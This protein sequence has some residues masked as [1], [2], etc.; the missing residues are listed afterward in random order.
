M[1]VNAA[2][3]DKTAVVATHD[4]CIGAADQ[5]MTQTPSAQPLAYYLLDRDGLVNMANLFLGSG[6]VEDP[7]LRRAFEEG[8]AFVRGSNPPDTGELPVAPRVTCVTLTKADRF[9]YL[10]R[11]LESYGNQTYPNR[12]LVIVG[13][14]VGKI[15]EY[16]NTLGRSDVQVVHAPEGLDLASRRNVGLDAASGEVICQW[17]DDDV[18]H[19]ERISGQLRAMAEAKARASILGEALQY[20]EQ[21][22]ELFWVRYRPELGG[23]TGTVMFRNAK[24]L[25]YQ[26]GHARGE[27]SLF[28]LNIND[29]ISIIQNIPYLYVYSIHGTNSFP[30]EHYR[31]FTQ[32]AAS[33]GDLLARRDEFS[34]ALRRSG[35]GGPLRFVG[36]DGPAFSFER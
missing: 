35:F 36:A 8:A 5:L 1:L 15:Q 7:K 19:P 32:S 27:D 18:S 11:S 22:G 4:R 14:D 28:L 10:K 2:K 21:S 6:Y 16:V 34:H 30:V 29:R 3:R 23:L 33:A 20:F 26:S 25:R 9:G 31:Q 17:D 24:D 13:A 12:D